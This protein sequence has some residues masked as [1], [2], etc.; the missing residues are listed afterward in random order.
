MIVFIEDNSQAYSHLSLS[1]ELITDETSLYSQSCWSFS[2]LNI[3]QLVSLP[4]VTCKAGEISLRFGG[5]TRW[6]GVCLFKRSIQGSS[7]VCGFLCGWCVLVSI[8]RLI[9]VG[10]RRNQKKCHSITIDRSHKWFSFSRE[11]NWIEWGKCQICFNS[12]NLTNDTYAP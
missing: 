1:G 10:D 7:H 8:L 2:L 12:L 6:R 3:R 9:E 11:Q 5:G 4:T